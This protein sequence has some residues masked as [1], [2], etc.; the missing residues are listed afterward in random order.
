[1]RPLVLSTAAALVCSAAAQNCTTCQSFGVDIVGGGTYFQNIASTDPFTALQEF[2]GCQDDSSYNLLVDP[3]GTQYQCN[4]TPMTP[5]DTQE[6]VTCPIDENQLVS[7]NWQLIIISNN[8]QCDP[9]DYVRQFS[10]EVGEQVTTTVGPT[11]TLISTTT[12]ISS[13]VITQV[14]S[15]TVSAPAVTTTG[16]A[17]DALFTITRYPLPSFVWQTRAIFT[18]TKVS[19]VPNVVATKTITTTAPCGSPI[20]NPNSAV[21]AAATA[22]RQVPDAWNKVQAV[23]ILGETIH[24][25]QDVLDPPSNNP[26][27]TLQARSGS[28]E[29]KRQLVQVRQI[30]KRGPDAP[31]ITVTDTSSTAT[32]TSTITAS[33]QYVTGTTTKYQTTTTTGVVT[34]KGRQQLLTTITAKAPTVTNVFLLPVTTIMVTRTQDVTITVTSAVS[35]C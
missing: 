5:A 8:G 22:R 18:K 33:T 17:S 11:I 24:A 25:W 12:P 6:L 21:A 31:T 4:N 7:G 10:L 26:V 9:I 19:Q 13:T 2:E 29:S 30:Q 32:A 14:S 20:G 27:P 23:K 3:S 28:L 1:M 35:G 15:I 34:V 16:S